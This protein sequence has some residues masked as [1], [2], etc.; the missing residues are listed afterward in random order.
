V[1]FVVFGISKF[2]NF[3]NPGKH[4]NLKKWKILDLKREKMWG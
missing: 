3:E 1:V 4:L 2:G